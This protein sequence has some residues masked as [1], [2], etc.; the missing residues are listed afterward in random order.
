MLHKN[1]ENCTFF[2]C[3]VNIPVV[4]V[5]TPCGDG[6]LLAAAV[7]DVVGDADEDSPPFAHLEKWRH[8]PLKT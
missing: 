6:V 5:A 4:V 1:Q 2:N 7:A 3:R 8:C